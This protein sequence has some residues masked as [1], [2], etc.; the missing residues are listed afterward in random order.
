MAREGEIGVVVHPR[1]IEGHDLLEVA[2]LEHAL[3][4]D[5][6]TWGNGIESVV[7][8]PT[9]VMVK[10][11]DDSRSG[12]RIRIIDFEPGQHVYDASVQIEIALFGQHQG[13][14]RSEGLRDGGDMKDGVSGD[15]LLGADVRD[16]DAG[17]MAVV[18]VD[19]ADS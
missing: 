4:G 17:G 15:G 11:V 10:Q 18:A 14:R 6:A 3:L 7:A 5:R 9:G 16:T 12:R 2:R 13:Q 8:A 19:D 1:L